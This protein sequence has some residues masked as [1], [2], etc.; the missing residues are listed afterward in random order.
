M[1]GIA[2][3]IGTAERSLVERMIDALRHR[4]P[5]GRRVCSHRQVQLAAATLATTPHAASTWPPDEA[6]PTSRRLVFDGELANARELRDALRTHGHAFESETDAEVVMRLYDEIGSDCARRLRGAFAFAVLDGARVLLARDP[7]G[8]RPLYYAAV[9]DSLFLFASEIK[10]ILQCPAFTPRLHTR[11]LADASLLG[12]A[13]GTDT[14]VDGV[15]ALAAGHTMTVSCSERPIAGAPRAYATPGITRDATL[16]IEAALPPLDRALTAAV[17]SSV[18]S[19]E[20]IGVALS[21]G[22]DSSVLALLARDAHPRRLLTYTV[23]DHDGHPDLVG[24][25]EVATRI[26][27]EHHSMVLSFDDYLLAIPDCVAAEERPVSLYGVPFFTLCRAMAART[28]VCLMGEGADAQFGGSDDYLEPRDLSPWP[29]RLDALDRVGLQPTDRARAIIDRFES[30]D[31]VDRSIEWMFEFNWREPLERWTQEFA[32]R[33]PMAAGVQMRLPYLDD[34]VRE[35]AGRCPIDM[36]VRPKTRIGKYLLK[37]WSLERFGEAPEIID[38]AL[39]TKL[40]FPSAAI[41]LRNRLDDLCEQVLPDDYLS[42]HELGVCF[43]S[44]LQLLLVDMFVDIV[45]THR[46]DSSAVGSVADFLDARAVRRG[47][48]KPERRRSRRASHASV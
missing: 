35:A 12:F 29:R 45:L 18:G 8:A 9:A 31:S 3:A 46:G 38:A 7:L 19:R 40:N 34:R 36:L 25:G 27:A 30:C 43:D 47:R 1:S 4:G 15:S 28:N 17:A 20:D 14:F 26:G 39:R 42:R 48:T 11:A 21:G 32:D 24:A 16:T 22:L 44:K 41:E 13:T 37:R 10:G 33:I 5:D 23:A 6:A 2:G